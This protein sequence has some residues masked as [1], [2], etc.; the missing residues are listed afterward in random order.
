MCCAR[1]RGVEDGEELLDIVARQPSTAKFIA[2]KLARRLVSDSPSAALVARAAETFTR[3]DGDIREVVRAIVTSPEF[4]ARA[5]YRAKVK[6]PFELVVSARRLI[7][8]S[9]DTSARTVGMIAR[10]GEPLFGHLAPNG[11]PGDWGSVD[12]RGFVARPDQLRRAGIERAAAVRADRGMAGV[13][14]AL[15]VSV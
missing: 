4:F 7:N 11:W 2:T 8:A 6:S 3:T 1:G 12:Q 9:P 14:T 13:V 15:D 5:N 10:L